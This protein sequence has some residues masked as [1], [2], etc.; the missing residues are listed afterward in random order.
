VLHPSHP[1]VRSHLLARALLAGVGL[2]VMPLTLTPLAASAAGTS[3]DYWGSV[4]TTVPSR[5]AAKLTSPTP[6]SLPGTVEQ[7][8]TSNSDEYALLSDGTVWAWG[9]GGEGQLGDGATADSLATAVQVQFP[10]GVTIAFLAG[11]AMPYDAGLAVDSLGHA[12]GWGYANLGAL[13]LGRAIDYLTPQEMPFT[14]VTQLAGAGDHSI[15][16]AGGDVYAC[17]ENHDGDMGTGTTKG[18]STPVAVQGMQGVSVAALV[19]SCV[20]SGILLTNG[21]YYDWGYDAKGQLGDGKLNV[22][23]DVPVQVSLPLAVT[24]VYE[25]GSDPG[26]G[27][28]LVELSD[29]SFRGW[30]D[31]QFGELG[32]GVHATGEASPVSFSAPAGVTYQTIVSSGATSYALTTAGAVYAWGQGGS[33]QIGTGNSANALTPVKVET[34][35]SYISATAQDV[36]TG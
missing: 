24:Q 4:F 18:S 12:W 22:S 29:G 27:Q 20:N 16:D 3:A 6:I 2:A 35:V 9:L 5:E 17:G 25:G 7:V 1:Q 14:D 34:G 11:D 10:A 15:V 23:S 28:T 36:V 30:G 26:N 32:N 19:A 31:D 21:D 13:C 33:G 8:A